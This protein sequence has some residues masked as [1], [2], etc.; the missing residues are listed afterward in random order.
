[1]SLEVSKV[2]ED[3]RRGGGSADQVVQVRH[4]LSAYGVTLIWVTLISYIVGGLSHS[5]WLILKGRL[6]FIKFIF[7]IGRVSPW[8]FG[9]FSCVLLV[10]QI[11][12]ELS[13]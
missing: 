13:D 1:M 8:L 6:A 2:L 7:G 9:F 10:C 12:E 4:E 11:G 5:T 3:V